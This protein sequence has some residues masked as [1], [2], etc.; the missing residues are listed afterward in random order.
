M[1]PAL[2]VRNG[3]PAL[4][5][6]Q[7]LL[8][9]GWAQGD[10][11]ASPWNLAAYTMVVLVE[12][13]DPAQARAAVGLGLRNAAVVVAVPDDADEGLVAR[14]RRSLR[15]VATVHDHLAAPDPLEH[16]DQQ[17]L[18]ALLAVAHGGS[19]QDAA[20]ASHVSV[21]TVN[22]R[23]DAASERLGAANR[24]AAVAL[25]RERVEEVRPRWR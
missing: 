13:V 4:A 1:A 16:L 15:R 9:A 3:R 6:L 7:V 20:D 2:V 24:R 17:Q 10:P 19:L 18:A 12:L 5:A 21:R 23:L 14:T 8:A 11:D 22:R 25:A